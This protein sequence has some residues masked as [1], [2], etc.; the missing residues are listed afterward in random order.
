MAEY[1]L[2]MNYLQSGNKSIVNSRIENN[3]DTLANLKAFMA[4]ARTGSF[5]AAARELKVSPSVVTKRI[6]QIE[7]RLAAPLFERTTRRVRLTAMG[8]HYLPTVQRVVAD[9]DGLFA[10]LGESAATLQG[11]VRIKAPGSLAVMQLGP[12]LHEFQREHPGISLDL[13]AL[14]RPVNPVDEGFDIALSV[15]PTAFGNVNEIPLCEIRRVICASPRYLLDKGRPM[16]PGDLMRHDILNFM[17]TGNV[18][19]FTGAAGNVQ[20]QLHPRLNTNEA[21]LLLSAALQHNGIAVLGTYLA[22]PALRSGELVPLLS[23][24][25]LP[26]LWLKALVPEGRAKVSRVQTLVQWLRGR[27]SPSPPWD[28]PT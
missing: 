27:L 6:S 12:M 20:V 26:A 2:P 1:Q 7:W 25:A 13:V 19:E 16:H 15:M 11:N 14:E 4:V 23:D 21:Q 22:G 10:D 9:M 17:P 24:Y 3:I 18:W 8:Q 5:S 28:V